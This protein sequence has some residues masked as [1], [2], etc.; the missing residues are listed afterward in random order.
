MGNLKTSCRHYYCFY[1]I[2]KKIIRLCGCNLK[3][4]KYPFGDIEIN[5]TKLN[6][7]EKVSEELS[8]GRNLS[9]TS[10]PKILR[11]NEN[12][13]VK[14]LY[15]KIEYLKNK[16]SRNKKYFIRKELNSLLS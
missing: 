2:A 11:C 4:S 10:H 16:I 8:L 1:D 9:K 15:K 7:G 5:I 3:N 14:F 13:D 12:Y 6:K